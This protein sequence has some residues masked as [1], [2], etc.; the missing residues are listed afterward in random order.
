MKHWFFYIRIPTAVANDIP[1][2]KWLIGTCGKGD[3]IRV[4]RA[5]HRVHREPENSIGLEESEDGETLYGL[6][7]WTDDKDKALMF[8]ESRNSKYFI[9][10]TIDIAQDTTEWEHLHSSYHMYEI[11][12][13][14]YSD[15]NDEHHWYMPM[16]N[17]ESGILES[18]NTTEIIDCIVESES[19]WLYT[20]DLS[21]DFMFVLDILNRDVL[22]ALDIM[23][24]S[25]MVVEYGFLGCDVCLAGRSNE[26]PEYLIEAYYCGCNYCNGLSGGYKPDVILD[27]VNTYIFMLGGLLQ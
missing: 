27:P 18:G 14:G 6:Y 22:M 8:R 26:D 1:I 25:E 9:C 3:G 24:W 16:T 12:H 17:F 13:M 15:C 11:L 5:S 20:E 2:L 19:M 10:K 23:A 21:D 7:A 4:N